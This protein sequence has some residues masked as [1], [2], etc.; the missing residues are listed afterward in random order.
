MTKVSTE[1]CAIQ[2]LDILL[3]IDNHSMKNR[4]PAKVYAAL[5]ATKQKGVVLVAQGLKSRTLSTSQKG[6]EF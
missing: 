4:R 5:E 1:G 2:E 6:R 3:A